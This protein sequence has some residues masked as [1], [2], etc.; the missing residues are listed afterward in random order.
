MLK[1]FAVFA[2]MLSFLLPSYS[3]AQTT[4]SAKSKT[5]AAKKATKSSVKKTTPAKAKTTAAAKPVKK[6]VEAAVEPAQS[7]FP[8]EPVPTNEAAPRPLFSATI[9]F[10]QDDGSLSSEA[11]KK[12]DDI[13]TMLQL[14]AED[15]IIIKGYAE[16]SQNGAKAVRDYFISK[17]LSPDRIT[18]Y[19]TGSENSGTVDIIGV[20]ES[21]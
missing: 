20:Q 9:Y 6:Q 18:V 8:A 4:K 19:S 21:L 11:I 14:F 5:T 1:M 15:R 12:L 17:G 2:I 3:Q 13:Y 7:A 10:N 16:G